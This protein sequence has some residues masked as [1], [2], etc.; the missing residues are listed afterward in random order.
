MPDAFVR[1]DAL[2]H[3]FHDRASLRRLSQDDDPLRH[4]A[5]FLIRI[6]NHCRIGNT[7][8]RQQHC[9]ELGRRHLESFVLDQ[10]LRTID[11]EEMPVF[12]VVPDVARV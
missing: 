10:L 6:W 3:K 12:I 5:C 11:D 1:R 8:M 2:G 9:L 4:L 7:R